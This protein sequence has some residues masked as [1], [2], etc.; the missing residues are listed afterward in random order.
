MKQVYNLK[1]DLYLGAPESRDIFLLGGGGRRGLHY[2]YVCSLLQPNSYVI[3]PQ[4]Q[5]HTLKQ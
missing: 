4:I 5:S 1:Q 3:Y 2:T